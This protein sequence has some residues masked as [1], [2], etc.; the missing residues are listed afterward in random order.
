MRVNFE[1][2]LKIFFVLIV[3]GIMGIA[4]FTYQYFES[5]NKAD[6]DLSHSNQLHSVSQA[7]L[8]ALQDLE[9]N[10]RAYS[11]TNDSGYIP[12]YQ[13]A[14]ADLYDHLGQM[15]RLTS[16]NAELQN[17]VRT[18]SILINQKIAYTER[19]IDTANVAGLAG[20]SN[21]FKTSP[22][23]DLMQHMRFS[24]R[25]IQSTEDRLIQQRNREY[26]LQLLNLRYTYY[27]MLISLLI[28][29]CIIGYF[30]IYQTRLRRLRERKLQQSEQQLDRKVN[31]SVQ[32]LRRQY[33]A[34]NEIAEMQSHQVRAPIA[35]ILGLI[36]LFNYNDPADPN[37]KDILLKLK[38]ATES[39]DQVIK[40]VVKMTNEIGA[41][42]SDKGDFS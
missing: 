28:A 30:T 32:E 40:D 12:P 36:N 5:V 1:T 15:N 16:D 17:R 14:K 42:K 39:F 34:L 2:R 6:A 20:A 29:V 11:L 19:L 10:T 41:L 23:N 37:N 33:Q 7:L 27:A 9:L 21:F 25:T 38:L 26:E 8:F 18:L 31:E 35:T 4:A 22:S 3:V 24:L 13:R